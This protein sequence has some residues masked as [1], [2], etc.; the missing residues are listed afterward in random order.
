MSVTGMYEDAPYKIVNEGRQIT[1]KQERLDG[2]QLK[3][4]WNIP[5]NFIDCSLPPQA[6]D[7][8]V[9]VLD[10]K[11]ITLSQ[12]PTNGN[13][14]VADTT[15]DINLHSGDKIDSGIVVGAFYH[16]KTTTS[17]IISD[18]DALTPYY[19]AGFAVDNVFRY[20]K[21]GVH[22]Y[23][24]SY[25]A[26]TKGQDLSG[27]QTIKL[28][29]P[30]LT[31]P[32][33]LANDATLY[34]FKIIID[35]VEYEWGIPG[36]TIQ[37][38]GDLIDAIQFR[39]D[40]INNPYIGV[41]P[42]NNGGL[43][44]DTTNKKIYLWNGHTHTEQTLLVSDSTPNVPPINS[45]W[46]DTTNNLL[47][48][49]YGGVWNIVPI[50]TS[51]K[52]P[53][54]QLQCDDIWFNG[55]TA[56]QWNTVIWEPLPTY[57]TNTDPTNGH[58]MSCGSYWFD[59]TS[60]NLYVWTPLATCSVGTITTGKWVQV[61]A[62]LHTTNPKIPLVG[63]YWYNEQVLKQ[64]GGTAWI[65]TT[66]SVTY[67]ATTPTAPILNSLWYN[68]NSGILQQ[69]DGSTWVNKSV[70]NYTTDPTI[71]T[72]G[73]LWWNTTTDELY[74][75]DGLTSTW[76]LVYDFTISTNNPSLPQALEKSS[77]WFNSSTNIIKIW[78]GMQWV[79]CEYIN[80]L[81]PPS[82]SI[83][84]VYYNTT[85]H[86]YYS[87]GG[88]TWVLIDPVT[89]LTDPTI[90]TPGVFW[91]SA[92]A[93]QVLMWNG[94]SWVSVMYN[95]TPYTPNTNSLWYNTSTNELMIWTG[96]SWS[97]G[98]SK[99]SIVF[100]SIGDIIITSNNTGSSSNVIVPEYITGTQYNLFGLTNPKGILSLPVK[101]I[102]KIDGTPLYKQL[103]VGTDGSSDERRYIIDRVLYAL[104]YPS[105]QVEL[106]KEQL[107]FCLDNALAAFRKH[108]G[109]AYERAFFFMDLEPGIQNYYLTDKA[110]GMN[111]VVRIQSIH[112]K[113]SSFIGTANN[114]GVYG[115]MVLQHL[116]QMG[117]YDLVSYAVISDYIEL[118]E[119]MFASRIVFRFNEHSRRLDIFQNVGTKE[120]VLI[121]CTIERTE[122]ELITDRISG[123]WILNW[124]TAA[125]CEILAQI[126]G[127]YSTL[128]GAGGGVSLNADAMRT[129]AEKLVEECMQE[130]D[131]YI[132]NEVEI[133]G[134]E[135][136]III[137]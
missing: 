126:R 15:A 103:G 59:E 4:S 69:W 121:D 99:A 92:L 85:D 44:F 56:Y 109:S 81:L 57:I 3:V 12:T 58:T 7:G 129:R 137:G 128:P 28:G 22:T 136:T 120:R 104:G 87:W 18:V 29:L 35:S 51:F 91:Y 9:V 72:P 105:I 67:T 130:I 82:V 5:A 118:L 47:Y 8:I 80:S 102:D 101:G 46:L 55:T 117:S 45:Y 74:M 42:P 34:T 43:Y 94:V 32:T 116:Y 134:L 63:E 11:E 66:N 127:K 125:A 113:T 98:E 52:H 13:T 114:Q 6:Y 14:Y 100:D 122:Q 53:I 37:T 90:L 60:N 124:A 50:S 106:T 111:K 62:V 97:N 108:S 123:K 93:N 10:T 89:A 17:L 16:D 112:R 48:K 25:G 96:T 49:W 40:T 1:I 77:A 110:V 24:Q 39:I 2:N 61:I 70:I 79:Q 71:T 54:N 78:D 75:W 135:S 38:F 131:N 33:N 115:Q 31:T 65:N 41:N 27:Y 30:G 23:A 84:D 119:I 26:P 107:E 64:W 132:A 73:D 83:G 95:T 19:I 133:Y 20:H 76:V 21:E 68:T 88:A 86:H 36:S